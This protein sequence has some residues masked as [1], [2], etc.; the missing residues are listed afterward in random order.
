MHFSDALH[1][2]QRHSH[3][4]QNF[5]FVVTQI[6]IKKARDDGHYLTAVVDGKPGTLWI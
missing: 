2:Q 5:S 6:Q 1:E 3:C 4:K